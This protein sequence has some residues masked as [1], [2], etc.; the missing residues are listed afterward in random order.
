MIGI[1]NQNPFLALFGT[2]VV[3]VGVGGI[4][5]LLCDFCDNSRFQKYID[6]GTRIGAVGTLISMGVLAMGNIVDALTKFIHLLFG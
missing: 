5:H 1:A 3:I 6:K 4:A 2:L